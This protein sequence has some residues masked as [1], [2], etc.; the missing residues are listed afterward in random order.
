MSHRVVTSCRVCGGSALAPVL[1]LGEQPL[2]NGFLEPEALSAREPTYPLALL[3]CETCA[4]GTLSV[5]VAPTD[6]FSRY[7]YVTGT[8]STMRHHFANEAT[9][10]RDRFLKPSDLAI[11][12]GS[13]DGTLLSA[14][15]GTH[16]VLGIEPAANIA[17]VARDRGISTECAFFG[18]GVAIA[19]ARAHGR[20]AAIIANNVIAHID[21][22]GNVMRGVDAL[23][24][25]N[26]VFVMEA[27]GLLDLLEHCALDTIY[28]EHLSYLSVTALARLAERHDFA[29]FDVEHL[30]VHL[31]SLRVF[32]D[33]RRRSP[34]PAV[35]QWLAQ[36]A[37]SGLLTAR[38]YARFAD[39]AMTAIREL[40]ALLDDEHARGR[41]V[42][43]YGAAAKGSTLLCAAGITDARLAYIVDR[44]PLKHGLFTPGT[45]IEV[46]GVERLDEDRPDTVLILAWNLADEVRA[47]LR[48][49]EELGGRFVVPLPAPRYL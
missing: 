39:Q 16:R 32:M 46:S 25:D 22:L 31:G 24:D 21:D 36:E 27:P 48:S 40:N 34:T 17:Q 13:N 30:D 49:F 44:N 12:I 43:G 29:V 35:A 47:Q 18:E 9:M 6:M 20:A 4:L 38:P 26:G 15:V 1:D 23:L 14:L 2:A 45:H 7:L 5:V 33:R 28:H 10:I 3:R 42:A 41:T 11:E 8:S 19:L 37:A